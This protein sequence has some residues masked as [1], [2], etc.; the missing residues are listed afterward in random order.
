MAL[1]KW[2]HYPKQWGHGRFFKGLWRLRVGVNLGLQPGFLAT[3][4]GQVGL[5][6]YRLVWNLLPGGDPQWYPLW[7]RVGDR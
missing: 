7:G 2:D 6:P 5:W 4:V 3:P 1:Y